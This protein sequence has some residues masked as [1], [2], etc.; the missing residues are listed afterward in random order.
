MHNVQVG[1]DP[2]PA[3]PVVLEATPTPRL[4]VEP[5]NLPASLTTAMVLVDYALAGKATPTPDPQAAA[6][7]IS[8]D[9][10]DDSHGMRAVFAHGTY[11]RQFLIRELPAGHRGH[12]E[13]AALRG[14]LARLD[15]DR[16]RAMVDEG[17]TGVL[18]YRKPAD[19]RPTKPDVLAA[20]TGW[21]LTE[22]ERR[23]A[24]LRDPRFVRRMMLAFL[25]AVWDLWF[26]R[27]WPE[28]LPVLQ[29]VAAAAPEPMPGTS[30]VQWTMQVSGLRPDPQYAELIDRAAS[31]VVSPCPGLGRSLALFE[32]AGD[33]WVLYSP[34]T[35]APHGRSGIA[36]GR[37]AQLAPTM[38]ALG[39]RTRLA[40]VLYLADHG[41]VFMQQLSDAVQVHQSTVS[42]QVA[43]LR[44]A[45]LVR[46]DDQRRI[47]ARLDVVRRTCQT[48]LEAIE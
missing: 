32:A 40:I 21:G 36:V 44:K 17:S 27:V 42:R 22:P 4:R 1:P 28:Q 5:P 38:Q 39:D 43:T 8:P 18:S 15:D 12:T 48:L 7:A 31:V 2:T 47:V 14:W 46:I 6:Q 30:G 9:L 35:P 41:P 23:A 26:V 34:Q 24:E 45:G 3:A 29:A 37:L 13:W 16:I 19:Q 33:I 20:V 25:D 10:A 11:L